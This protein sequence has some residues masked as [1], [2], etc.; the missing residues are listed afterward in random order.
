MSKVLKD[1]PVREF[2]IPGGIE[3]MKIDPRTGELSSDPD[4]VMEC[5]IEGTAPGQN[6]LFSSRGTS[7][8]FK[9]DFNLSAKGH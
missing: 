1:V 4:A 7:D 2:P 3:F 8:F 9:L 6:V 5:F